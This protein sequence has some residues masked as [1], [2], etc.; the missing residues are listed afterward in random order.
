MK[1]YEKLLRNLGM[2]DY[3]IAIYLSLI[4]HGPMHISAISESI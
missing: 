4:E 1:K 2:N 3:E